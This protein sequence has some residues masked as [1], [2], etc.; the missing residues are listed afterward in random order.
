MS[1]NPF[2]WFR[3]YSE[4]LSDRKVARIAKQLQQPKA[5]IV[6]VWV[7]LLSLASESPERGKL[8]ISEGI[9]FTTD[10]LLDEIDLGEV[11]SVIVDAFVGIGMLSIEDNIYAISKWDER[12]PA[13]DN[14]TERV[15]KH[16]AKKKQSETLPERYSNALD[17]DKDKETDKDKDYLN[18]CAN[19]EEGQ[20]TTAHPDEF[21]KHF[22]YRDEFLQIYNQQTGETPN[23]AEKGEIVRL[24]QDTR[25]SPDQWGAAIIAAILNWSGHNRIPPLQRMIE[26]Y[27][28]IQNGGNYDTFARKKWGNGA[29]KPNAPPKQQDTDWQPVYNDRGEIVGRI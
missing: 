14:S 10:E 6:G 21:Q 9:P 29:H 1:H 16:R 19:H 13:S 23:Q 2:P 27:Q 20:E 15:R 26:V 4:I 3:M 22:G 12:Q 7:L 17:K 18:A 8:L 11:G 28:E 25:A 24:S 5:V